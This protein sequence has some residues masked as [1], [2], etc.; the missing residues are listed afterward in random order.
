MCE[1]DTVPLT[2]ITGITGIIILVKV[3]TGDTN[4][5]YDYGDDSVDHFSSLASAQTA[6][7]T[8]SQPGEYVVT[9]T[10]FNIAGQI[11]QHT[12]ITVLGETIVVFQGLVDPAEYIV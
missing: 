6:Q 8:Y 10:A 9:V 7:H 1:V 5:T 2:G 12:T 11:V 3:F 4:Y